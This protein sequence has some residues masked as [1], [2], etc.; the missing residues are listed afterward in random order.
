MA[1]EHPV[2]GQTSAAEPPPVEEPTPPFPGYGAT[3]RKMTQEAWDYW[4]RYVKAR[5]PK[6]GR[7]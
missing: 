3:C 2:N 1:D 4:G 6:G 5:W 7:R